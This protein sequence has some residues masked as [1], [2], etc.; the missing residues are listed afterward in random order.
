VID[1]TAAP[2]HT[3]PLQPLVAAMA[4]FGARADASAALS[5]PPRLAYAAL[6]RPA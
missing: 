3:P 6:A 5:P 2:S 1:P 4:S